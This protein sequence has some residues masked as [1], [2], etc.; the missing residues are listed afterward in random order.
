MIPLKCNYDTQVTTLLKIAEAV[1]HPEGLAGNWVGNDS[2]K[3][4]TF[5]TCDAQKK[6]VTVIN[7]SKQHFVGRISPAFADLGSLENLFLNDNSLFGSIPDN[8]IGLTQLQIL[9]VTNNNLTGKVPAFTSKVTLK[10]EGNPLLGIPGTPSPSGSVPGAGIIAGVSIAV[11]IL[12]IVVILVGYKYYKKKQDDGTGGNNEGTGDNV[13]TELRTVEGGN[14]A[15]SVEVLRRATNN[16]DENNFIG[17]GGFGNV[18]RGQLDDGTQIAV[19]RMKFSNNNKGQR[20][21]EAE[22]AV[23]TVVRHTHL[24]ALLGACIDGDERFLVY[25]YM[26]QGP[27]SRHLFEWEGNGGSSLTWKQ[28]VSIALDVAR[29]VDYMHS[30]AYKSFIHRDLKPTN[31]LLN[32]NMRAKVADFGLVR[33]VSDRNS[34]VETGFG[35]TLGYVAPETLKTV[36]RLSYLTSWFTVAGFGSVTRKVDVYAFGAILM[37]II[38]GRKAL[39]STLADDERHLVPW[40]RSR[41]LVNQDSV[42]N[43]NILAPLAEKWNPPEHEEE[44]DAGGTDLHMSLPQTLL[45]WQSEDRMAANATGHYTDHTHTSKLQD[46]Q[47]S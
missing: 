42:R 12:V 7:F 44:E 18:Y 2:C 35:G 40:F 15:I 43:F 23:L 38:T 4:W 21:F 41:L 20:E 1:G 9:D 34:V 13:A 36:A 31:I 39:D 28:R 24:V 5:V 45:G 16:F 26:P 33:N 29:G 19:K 30:R 14:M 22:I 11:I 37:E 3:N 17:K 27:L 10:L 46:T 6:K 32:D 47:T 25:E 8:L